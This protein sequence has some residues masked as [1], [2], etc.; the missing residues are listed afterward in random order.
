VWLLIEGASIWTSRAEDRRWKGVRRDNG[1]IIGHYWVFRRRLVDKRVDRVKRSGLDVPG[2][3][4]HLGGG[5]ITRACS[6]C[7]EPSPSESRQFSDQTALMSIREPARHLV[8]F[9]IWR[10]I[11]AMSFRSFHF[12]FLQNARPSLLSVSTNT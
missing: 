7:C 3:V 6:L 12:I 2:L 11:K 1:H 9:S 5:C 8:Y 10:V 4:H